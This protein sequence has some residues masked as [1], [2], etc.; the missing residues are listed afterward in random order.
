MESYGE[1]LIKFKD[2]R[3]KATCITSRIS[4]QLFECPTAVAT[5][6]VNINSTDKSF[7]GFK[8]FNV[9]T[10]VDFKIFYQFLSISTQLLKIKFNHTQFTYSTEIL[11]NF[12][13]IDES[14]RSIHEF[15]H[16]NYKCGIFL[17]KNDAVLN[18]DQYVSVLKI[19]DS[20]NR[21]TVVPLDF[22]DNLLQSFFHPYFIIISCTTPFDCVNKL[23]I[24]IDDILYTSSKKMLTEICKLMNCILD[25][26]ASYDTYI[27]TIEKIMILSFRC[28]PYSLT[29]NNQKK[30]LLFL[31]HFST[32]LDADHLVQLITIAHVLSQSE[33]K[34]KK[35]VA[36]L[37]LIK[38][39]FNIGHL[40]LNSQ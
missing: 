19:V 29:K 6:S 12:P 26:S 21:C 1:L 38:K 37:K 36:D 25:E 16:H 7:C 11:S 35:F 2:L 15:I 31:S 20:E 40:T 22:S 24:S 27:Y 32:S 28:R 33:T 3:P 34:F 13:L 39:N 10:Y 4:Y 23:G 5:M 18:G 14:P 9:H 17:C 8:D 30:L